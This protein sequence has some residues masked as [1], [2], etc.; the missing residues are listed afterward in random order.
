[1]NEDRDTVYQ[2]LKKAQAA[3]LAAAS[4]L[5]L[6]KDARRRLQERLTFIDGIHTGLQ[7]AA[8]QDGTK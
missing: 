5:Y 2:Q 8:T 4:V 3:E 1:M 6:A 7:M